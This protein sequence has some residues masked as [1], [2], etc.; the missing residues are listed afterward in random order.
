MAKTIVK[1]YQ[2]GTGA[3]T[4]TDGG[5][6]LGSGAAAVTATAVLADG[7]MLVGDGT[8]DP[9]LESGATL[10]TSIGVDAA[11]T[12]NS[13]NVTLAGTPDYI[14][15]SGQTITR[16]QVDLTADVTGTLP[17]GNGGTGLTSTSTLLNSNVTPTSLSLVIGSDVQAY[18]A[19]T[20]KLDVAQTFT[21][22][23]R[24]EVTTL[25]DGANIATDLA[26]S[27]NF[28]VT[29]AGNRVLD[30]P[31]NL[32]AGQ[33]GVIVITQDGTGSRTLDVSA[34]YWHFEGGTEP[35]LTTGAGGAVDTLVY[36]V[37]STSSIQAVLLKDLK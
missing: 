27:N 25:S 16:A 13:T 3:E 24:G 30:N 4:L 11:G 19:D 35:T 18:D 34:S 5:V 1:V 2:G 10:R 17:A 37:A 20:A 6:L 26:L 12:D 28:K 9:A 32:V 31:S 8:T 14:T 22:G 21:A 29:L 15:I 33:S 23:Q 7:E 36:Y